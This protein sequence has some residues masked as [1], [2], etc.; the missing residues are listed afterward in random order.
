[1]TV[2]IVHY[3]D[4]QCDVFPALPFQRHTLLIVNITMNSP[5][6]S[7]LIAQNHAVLQKTNITP[8][9]MEFCFYFSCYF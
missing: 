9:I 1:M 2:N 6:S 4:K 3:R 8:F 7:L 5:Y